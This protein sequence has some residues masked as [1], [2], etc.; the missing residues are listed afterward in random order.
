MK[1][2]NENELEFVARHYEED[3]LNT[4]RAWRR[5]Q[6]R[7]GVPLTRRTAFRRIAASVGIMLIVGASLACGFWYVRR[8]ATLLEAPEAPTSSV[9]APYRFLQTK[10]ES[11]V[12]KYDNAP[13]EDVLGELSTYYDRRIVL[14][15]ASAS[16]RHISGEIEATSLEEVV[17]I[18]EATLDVEIEIRNEN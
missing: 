10:D 4:S 5:F 8:Q 15:S 14:Q 11:I 13:I 6:Q 2:T 3:A 18:L 12:L 16:G 9:N 1:E 7:V 17:E